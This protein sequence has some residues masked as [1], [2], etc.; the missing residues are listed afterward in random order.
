MHYIRSK[1]NWIKN[2]N[3]YWIVENGV[4]L[5]KS[6]GK[7][8]AVSIRTEKPKSKDKWKV[9]CTGLGNT[10][11]TLVKKTIINRMALCWWIHWKGRTLIYIQTEAFCLYIYPNVRNHQVFCGIKRPT[12]L[13]CALISLT[14]RRM[15]WFPKGCLL[16]SLLNFSLAQEKTL[17]Q[18]CF[19]FLSNTRAEQKSKKQIQSYRSSIFPNRV[20]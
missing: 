16:Y 1:G 13:L 20:P 6:S 14:E 11:T 7:T 17:I 12:L 9:K 15:V 10:P 4:P 5:L 3:N 18:Y 19:I 8:E 2:N